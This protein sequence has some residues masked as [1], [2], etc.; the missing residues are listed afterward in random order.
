M[1]ADG[2]VVGLTTAAA[3][4]RDDRNTQQ[5]AYLWHADTGTV[6]LLSSGTS[7]PGSQ[8]TGPS[9]TGITPSGDSVFLTSPE[10]LLRGH[11]SGQIASYAVR[12]DGGFPEPP[13]P[14]GPCAG[15]MCQDPPTAAP[16]LPNIGSVT[17]GGDGNM[18]L[19]PDR[20]RASVGVSKLKSV[21]GAVAKLKVR[22]PDAGRI[23]VVGALI[24][25]RSVSASKPGSYSLRIAL[26]SKAKKKLKR[27]KKLK[28]GA[29]VSYRA[30][31]GQSASKRVSVTFKQP[32]PQRAKVKKGGR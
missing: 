21:T 26:S 3:L 28:I 24:A 5:D 31:D 2:S 22:V 12:R 30:K 4:S 29:R 10:S 13:S 20:I 23:S 15:D 25:R 11:T 8:Y 17:F 18:P 1:A 7:K 19:A 9:V 32:K 14:G 6:T 27:K 16:L